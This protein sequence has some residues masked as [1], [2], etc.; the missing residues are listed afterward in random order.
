MGIK[1][2]KLMS[3]KFL[4]SHWKMYSIKFKKY[5]GWLMPKISEWGRKPDRFCIVAFLI[6]SVSASR[7]QAKS[8]YMIGQNVKITHH[9]TFS[10]E[11]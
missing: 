8:K 2:K 7:E 10:I 11:I 6:T 3:A 9:K 5:C 4:K 1:Q